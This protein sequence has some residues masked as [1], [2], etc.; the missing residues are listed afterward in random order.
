MGEIKVSASHWAGLSQADR[1]RI[2]AILNK[3]RLIQADDRIVPTPGISMPEAG[4]SEGGL[5]KTLCDVAEAAACQECNKL[6]GIAKDLCLA[7]AKAAG[8]LCRS[9]C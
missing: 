6:D 5:C 8:D 2:E 4:A 3:N 7:A 9:K 1:S